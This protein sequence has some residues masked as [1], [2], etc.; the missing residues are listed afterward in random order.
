MILFEKPGRGNTE[1]TLQIAVDK[2]E[3]LDAAIVIASNSGSTA[4]DL[5]RILKDRGSVVP[6]VVVTSVY[7]MKQPGSPG[8]GGVR[9]AHDPGGPAQPLRPGGH[10]GAGVG[11]GGLR[12]HP[13]KPGRGVPGAGRPAAARRRAAGETEM[14]R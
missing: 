7:G 8:A 6:V 5:I 9:P 4:K 13:A 14:T 1:K 10:A 2:A 3:S 11:A 12:V